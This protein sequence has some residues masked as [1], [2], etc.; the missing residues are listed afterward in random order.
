MIDG[1]LHTNNVIGALNNQG[2]ILAPGLS[3]GILTVTDDYTQG[4]AATLE[5]K[6]GGLFN[7]GDDKSLTEFD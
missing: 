2:R 4:A 5:I 3:P 7:G 6:P 1:I